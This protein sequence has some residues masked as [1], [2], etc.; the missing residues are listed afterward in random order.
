MIP[1]CNTCRFRDATRGLWGK[2]DCRRYPPTT[3]DN[4]EWVFPL[5]RIDEVCGEWQMAEPAVAQPD[6][7]RQV[8][9]A[10]GAEHPAVAAKRNELGLL[11]WGNP[12]V[13]WHSILNKVR[14][15]V[16]QDAKPK[17]RGML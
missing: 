10:E 2:V 4:G 6:L 5:L 12:D 3:R 13:S 15:L 9:S 1:S 14:A 11:V 7:H 17:H 8:V 16:E